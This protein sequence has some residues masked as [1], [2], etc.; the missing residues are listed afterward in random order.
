MAGRPAVQ[1]RSGEIMGIFAGAPRRVKACHK[2]TYRWAARWGDIAK[3]IE[4]K[5]AFLPC[6]R[7]DEPL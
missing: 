6:L 5:P 7:D 4:K 3:K 2:G 1:E